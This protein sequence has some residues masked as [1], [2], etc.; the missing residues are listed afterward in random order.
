MAYIWPILR[1]LIA[2]EHCLC[3]PSKIERHLSIHS[4]SSIW[5]PIHW[6]SL[7]AHL[8]FKA[9]PATINLSKKT[10]SPTPLVFKALPIT[11]TGPQ[12]E[13][14]ERHSSAIRWFSITWPQFIGM[15]LNELQR[16]SDWV[17]FVCI[18]L[19]SVTSLFCIWMSAIHP[20]SLA[21]MVQ[22]MGLNSNRVLSI[23]TS[24]SIALSADLLTFK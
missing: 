16:E 24:L 18:H 22:L 1:I 9:S 12:R 7:I 4:I 10:S 20:F 6:V 13:S 21:F 23:S 14:I 5:L 19:L 17:P 15:H 2:S 11:S 8:S 3:I